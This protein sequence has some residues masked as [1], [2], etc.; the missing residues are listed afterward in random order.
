MK[1]LSTDEVAA[2]VNAAKLGGIFSSLEGACYACTEYLLCGCPVISTSS[3]SGIREVWLNEGNNIM[4]PA[5]ED[6]VMRGFCAALER[7]W[8][9]KGIREDALRRR[10]GF[11]ATLNAEVQIILNKHGIALDAQEVAHTHFVHKMGL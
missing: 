2:A 5:T 1:Y 11:W 10:A 7:G 9:R 3:D 4:V 8:D 6:G